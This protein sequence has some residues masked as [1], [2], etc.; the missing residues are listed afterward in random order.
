MPAVVAPSVD[1]TLAAPTAP[2]ETA[3]VIVV[4][5]GPG[6]STAAYHLAAAGLDVHLLE[7][8]V[9]PRE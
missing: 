8:T 4:G 1:K 9:F 6:G 7:K 5:A 2:T 3:D